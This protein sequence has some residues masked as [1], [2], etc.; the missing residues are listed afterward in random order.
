[1]IQIGTEGGVLP[2]PVTLPNSPIG[3]EYNRRSITVTNVSNKNLMLGP[4]ER[5]DVIVDF[6]TYAGKTLILY[7]DSGAPI[8]AFDPRNDYYT[9]DPDQRDTGG[10][11]STRPGY[12]PNTR[13]VMV[14]KVAATR[15]DPLPSSYMSKLRTNLAAAYTATQPKPIVP[16]TAYPAPYKGAKDTYSRI[17]DNYLTFTPIGATDAINSV[18]VTDG[19][20]GYVT[21]PNVTISAPATG[22]QATATAVLTGDKVTAIQITDGGSGYSGTPPAA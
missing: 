14:F 6:S 4:A 22:T 17:Q 21:T 8:P 7:N 11:R 18:T 2:N 9:G 12:G 10:T 5:A 20:S 3:Y 15:P 1:M 16:E 13:T 19:G